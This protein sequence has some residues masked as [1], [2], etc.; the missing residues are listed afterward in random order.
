M[1]K[2][3]NYIAAC[4]LGM[5]LL[6][7][8]PLH[9]GAED[10][11]QNYSAA[12]GTQTSY[13]DE[14]GTEKIIYWTDKITPPTMNGPN[15][16]NSD[17]KRYEE[18]L[19]GIT[20]VDYV[21]PYKPGNG[22]YDVNKTPTQELDKNLCF[23]AAASNMLHWWMDQNAGY[24]DRYLQLYPNAPKAEEIRMFKDSPVDQ[25]NSKIYARFVEQFAGRQ[26]GYWAD[27]LQDQFI[28]GYP[29]KANGGVNDPDWDGSALLQNGPD[30]RGGFFFQVFGADILTQ[31]RTYDY[32]SGSSYQTLSQDVK[33]FFQQGDAVTLTYDMGASAHV[34]TLW[35]AEY[36]PAG[37]LSAVYY[38]D[39]DDAYD[40]G[41]HRYRVVNR[42]GIPYVTTDIRDD[43]S[44]SRVTYV[45]TL[46]TGRD[47][48]EKMLAQSAIE[49]KLNWG[50][51]QFVYN[52][53]PQKP[54]LAAWN[55]FPGDDVTVFA[56]GEQTAAGTYTASARMT[57]TAANKYTLPTDCT[58][59]FTIAQSA[60]VF[61][62]GLKLYQGGKEAGAFALGETVTVK[63]AP[64]AT[65]TKPPAT[66]TPLD[67]GVPTDG[68]MALYSGGR[69]LAG[70]VRAD[71]NGLYTLTC[72]VS[73]DYF[74]VGENTLTA[75]FYGDSN[76]ADCEGTAKMIVTDDGK[77]EEPPVLPEK[78]EML[79]GTDAMYP[80]TSGGQLTFRANGD[81]SKFTDVRVDGA[82]VDKHCYTAV[83]GST[84][85]TFSAEY[86][87]T[88]SVGTHT[89]EI[90]YTDGFA[91]CTFKITDSSQTAPESG[92]PETNQPGT[93]QPE[94]GQPGTNQP[95]GSQPGT[96]LPGIVQ[97]ETALPEAGG[98]GVTAHV[99]ENS[100]GTSR[101]SP[102]TD[103]GAVDAIDAGTGEE[104]GETGHMLAGL[105][106]MLILAVGI[107]A[108]AWFRYK[109]EE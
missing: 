96:V 92:T 15:A 65:G 85:I 19:N 52:G 66:G 81:F 73:G 16:A 49:L 64:R 39:S 12:A 60:T 87:G 48:W 21:A 57:G 107:G 43:G 91:S 102:L 24:I 27:L 98:T 100:D 56:E 20:Y 97:P 23:S 6:L 32:A 17:F 34:V 86:L 72:V 41:M 50:S 51:T 54:E 33:S 90:G 37:N 5:T 99:P 103:G 10:A 95:E 62:G 75:K 106:G 7:A 3:K 36:D 45:T 28:N 93:S 2:R 9:V 94:G 44:G 105:T 46:S 38:T 13:I 77:L 71:G 88:L 25:Q 22:W 67:T 101:R 31:R 59:Q 18:T 30:A 14:N 82:V 76:M 26:E 58:K 78:Y 70:P 109:T 47:R 55:I 83:S 69:L 61:D 79:S 35:G 63:A 40:K 4:V 108:L 84:I 1:K 8:A 74:G 53:M 68:Q 42:G 80:N 104:T 89:L 11:G 29:P